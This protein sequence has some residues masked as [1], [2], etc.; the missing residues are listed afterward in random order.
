MAPLFLQWD[1]R[2]R[3]GRPRTRGDGQEYNLTHGLVDGK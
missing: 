3:L 1:R 2:K